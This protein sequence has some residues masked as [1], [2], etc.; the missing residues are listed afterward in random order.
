MVN[1]VK[2]E[3]PRNTNKT[4]NICDIALKRIRK[5]CGKKKD[6][7]EEE[8]KCKPFFANGKGIFIIEKLPRDIT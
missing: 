5:Y 2:S 1:L 4:L 3:Q 8:K 6:I 7:T